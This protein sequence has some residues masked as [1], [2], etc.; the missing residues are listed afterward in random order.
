MFRRVYNRRILQLHFHRIIDSSRYC[1]FT[2]LNTDIHVKGKIQL[3]RDAFHY[4]H[5]A[6]IES[7]IDIT[8]LW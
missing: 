4:V 1:I 6:I 7:H 5:T 8:Y 2:I 3:G